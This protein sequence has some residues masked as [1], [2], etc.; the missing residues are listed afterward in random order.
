M[1]GI[2]G[3]ATPQV[4]RPTTTPLGTPVGAKPA[5]GQ[6]QFSIGPN[7]RIAMN[8]VEF[9]AH[10]PRMYGRVGQYLWDTPTDGSMY[11]D[12]SG[13][14]VRAT[15]LLTPEQR[16]RLNGRA[17]LGQSGFGGYSEY[18]LRN[19][20]GTPDLSGLEWDDEFGLLTNKPGSIQGPDDNRHQLI[21]Q[22]IM[23]LLAGGT[24]AA[25]GLLGGAAANA[26]GGPAATGG[27]A[28][29]GVTA[30]GGGGV[31]A[32]VTGTA[33][34]PGLGATAGGG[35]TIGN[36]IQRYGLRGLSML[37]GL[38]N[39]SG[40]G[41]T[42][43]GT[44][45]GNGNNGGFNLPGLLQL[46]TG[47]AAYGAGRE[48]IEDYRNDVHNMINVGTGGVTNDMRKPAQDTLVG[49]YNGTIS[50]DEIFN[51][52]PGLRAL[53]DRGAQN[54]SRKYA[55]EGQSG[56]MDEVSGAMREWLDYDKELSSKAWQ[57][58]INNLMQM[59]GFNINPGQTAA[60]GMRSLG[61]VYG[62]D[63]ANDDGLAAMITRALGQN[64]GAGMDIN[65]MWD[66]ISSIFGGNGIPDLSGTPDTD[67]PE[68]N[69]NGDG[70]WDTWGD[71]PFT[72]P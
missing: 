60:A 17:Q 43:Q 40:G 41:N 25:S 64:G 44:G 7:G 21:G 23:G 8:G 6:P 36:L 42:G 51:R 34:V 45:N 52:V 62:A 55:A 22:I 13:N 47:G 16:A 56:P 69:D 54:I 50:G 66:F 72:G 38:L 18:F 31:G 5:Q 48:D 49:L 32:G 28:G 70:W 10:D 2:M 24:A 71:D 53:S 9:D 65:G 11:T 19:P 33:A 1:P 30:T 39:N 12:E 58:E 68:I 29:L 26:I 46:L 20:D 67:F 63:R 3:L 61:D 27:G 37:G 15:N 57:S 35:S 59:G 14:P 4:R